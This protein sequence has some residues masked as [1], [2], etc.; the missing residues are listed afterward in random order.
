[1]LA[2]VAPVIS[3]GGLASDE[4]L[5]PGNSEKEAAANRRSTIADIRKSPEILGKYPGFFA[6]NGQNRSWHANC[7]TSPVTVDR[8]RVVY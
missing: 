2:H 8:L 1:L 7:F 3:L 4:L 6:E 5:T